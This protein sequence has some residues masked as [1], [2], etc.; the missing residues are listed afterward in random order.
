MTVPFWCLLIMVFIPYVLSGLGGY[1]KT[2]QFG[3]VDI[4]NPRLQAK[5]LEGAGHRTQ[6][7]QENAWE[8]VAVFTAA[9][10]I[11]HFAGADAAASANA[12]MLFIAARIAHPII[13]LADIGPLRTVAFV[14][15]LGACI[16]LFVLA[17]NAPVLTALPIVNL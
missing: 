1:F 3:S 2:K 13:Y 6:A 14:V 4:K 9:V 12:A 10:M 11:A 17:A 5:L 8:A 15:G 7:A 16:W